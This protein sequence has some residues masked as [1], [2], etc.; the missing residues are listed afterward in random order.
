MYI[1]C[2]R[3]LAIYIYWIYIYWFGRERSDNGDEGEGRGEMEG[4]RVGG[5][6]TESK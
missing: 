4:R 1:Y 5:V 3:N 6:A 2:L